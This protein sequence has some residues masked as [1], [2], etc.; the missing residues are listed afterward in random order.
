MVPIMVPHT[1]EKKNPNLNMLLKKKGVLLL[2]WVTFL[3]QANF[4]QFPTLKLELLHIFEKKGILKC[5]F[6]NYECNT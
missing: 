5:I 2:V 6:P 4:N 3:L 1:N